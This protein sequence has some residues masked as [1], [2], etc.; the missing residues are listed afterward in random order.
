[1]HV[2]DEVVV[3]LSDEFACRLDDLSRHRHVWARKTA[4]TEKIAHDLWVR[5]RSDENDPDAGLTLFSGTGRPEDDLLAIIDTVELHHG[6]ASSGSQAVSLRVLG[7]EPSDAI[8][9]AIGT[10][11]FTRVEPTEGGFIARWHQP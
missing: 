9:K 11:G 2:D 4:A 6:L 10:L 3:V 1:M 5:P 7:V 8:R